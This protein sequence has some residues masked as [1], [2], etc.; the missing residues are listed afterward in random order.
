MKE[1]RKFGFQ[2]GLA[3]NILGCI[4]FYREKPHFI[5]FTGIGFLTL[6]LALMLPAALAPLKKILDFV[7]LSIGRIVNFVSL[8]IVFYLIFAPI[9]IL[10][11]LFGRDLL[12]EKIDK[13]ADSYWIERKQGVFSKNSYERMG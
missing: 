6:I 7:I 8:T 5:W 13:T 11:K 10:L 2:L 12:H 3:L 1:L 4:M 9:A